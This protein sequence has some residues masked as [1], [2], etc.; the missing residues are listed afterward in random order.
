MRSCLTLIS[1][2]LASHAGAQTSPMAPDIVSGF[3]APQEQ[4]DYVKRVVMIPMRDGVRLHTVIVVPKG[5][6][7]APIILTRTPY[8]ADGRARRNVSPYMQSRCRRATKYSGAISSAC[9][10]TCAANTAPRAIT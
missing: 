5:A 6:S 3:E 4:A 10:R 8:N 9:S 7:K 1:L 2:L